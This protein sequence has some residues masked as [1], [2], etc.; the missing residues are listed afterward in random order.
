MSHFQL[1]FLF[2]R[3]H[4]KYRNVNELRADVEVKYLDLVKTYEYK[5]SNLDSTILC[6]DSGWHS[7]SSLL[8]AD[9][10]SSLINFSIRLQ[11]RAAEK[12]NRSMR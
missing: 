3:H 6:N 4:I 7:A 5:C 10:Y 1:Y 11:N 12:V 2:N 8:E 9:T